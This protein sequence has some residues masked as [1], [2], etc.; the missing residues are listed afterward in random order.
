LS[1][2]TLVVGSPP[3]PNTTLEGLPCFFQGS[4]A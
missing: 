1:K 4:I 3:P 2:D